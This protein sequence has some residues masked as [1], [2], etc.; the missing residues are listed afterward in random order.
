MTFTHYYAISL[1]L[2]ATSTATFASDKADHEQAQQLRLQGEI[3]PLDTILSKIK[4]A[5]FTN[6]LELELEKEHGR[7]VYEIETLNHHNQVLEIYIDAKTGKL[8][9]QELEN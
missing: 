1:L 2:L 3:L 8:L 6:I 5:G 4:T 7:W 9:K